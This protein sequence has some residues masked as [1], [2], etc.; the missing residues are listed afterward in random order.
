VVF[1]FFLS[2]TN[3]QQSALFRPADLALAT[4]I[5][6]HADQTNATDRPPLTADQDAC[7]VGFLFL[8][9]EAKQCS[10]HAGMQI[11]INNIKKGSSIYIYHLWHWIE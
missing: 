2:Q 1:G 8:T 9:H 4:P 5:L 6:S 10:G 7:M 3:Q 11:Y